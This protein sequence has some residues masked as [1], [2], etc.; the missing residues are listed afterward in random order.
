MKKNSLKHLMQTGIAGGLLLTAA[1]AYAHF[2]WISVP[3]YSLKQGKSSPVYVIS[4]HSFPVDVPMAADRLDS[5]ELVGPD[6]NRAKVE[7]K[8]TIYATPELKT[9]GTYLLVGTQKNA[10]FTRTKDG[11]KRQS[12]EGLKDVIKCAYSAKTM[13]AILSTGA[14][15]GSLSNT[16]GHPLEIIPLNNPATLKVNDSLDVQVLL[17]GKPY[18]GMVFATYSGFSNE[19]NTYAY[20]VATDEE[21]KASIRLLSTGSWLV[22][23]SVEQPYPDPKV[24]DVESYSSTLTFGVQ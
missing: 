11:G 15:D 16:F 12:K 14:G 9:S 10:F 19:E 6:G 17:H 18:D 20:A 24:C 8:G 3:D 23:A 2:P 5:L 1:S 22:K 7:Q 4:G 21:G 13:K